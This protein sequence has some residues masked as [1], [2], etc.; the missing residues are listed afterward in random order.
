MA[1]RFTAKVTGARRGGQE[2]LRYLPSNYSVVAERVRMS[3]NDVE[4]SVVY[5]SGEDVAGW[6]MAD[7]VA[8]RL[9]SGGMRVEVL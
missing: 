6:T 7:Y 2:V 5:I 8:P 4:E 9:A 1:D 3:V